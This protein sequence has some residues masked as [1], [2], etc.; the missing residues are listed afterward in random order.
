[1]ANRDA[2]EKEIELWKNF[3]LLLLLL[4]G[5]VGAL[6]YSIMIKQKAVILD[7]NITITRIRKGGN[8]FEQAEVLKK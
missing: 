2:R 5:I 8:G 1:M 7:Q 4:L 3:S 6:S